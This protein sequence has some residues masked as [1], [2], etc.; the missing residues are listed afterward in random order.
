MEEVGGLVASYAAVMGAVYFISS[1]ADDALSPDIVSTVSN[2]LDRAKDQPP[3]DW[4]GAFNQ[5]SDQV[6]GAKF[7][8]LRAYFTL[9][10]CTI[11][12]CLMVCI[13]FKLLY[14][15]EDLHFPS[16]FDADDR[17]YF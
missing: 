7:F 9:L 16:V 10:L 17:L 3:P 4:I 13:I 1:K 11:F 2:S 15:S 5:V 12:V 6:F 14:F 8:S